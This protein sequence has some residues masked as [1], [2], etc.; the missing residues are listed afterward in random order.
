MEF[1]TVMGGVCLKFPGNDA[2]RTD[3][4]YSGVPFLWFVSLGRQRNEQKICYFK[5]HFTLVIMWT[6]SVIY[7]FAEIIRQTCLLFCKYKSL[8]P[9]NISIIVFFAIFC[10]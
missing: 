1:H 9:L 6:H 4:D 5:K 3:Y 7:L 2:V 10:K 8:F